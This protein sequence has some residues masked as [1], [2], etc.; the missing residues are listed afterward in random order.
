MKNEKSMTLNLSPP[1]EAEKEEERSDG[2]QWQTA[3]KQYFNGKKRKKGSLKRK[4]G[5]LKRSRTMT[6]NV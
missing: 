4:K 1:T 3:F 2:K 5:G 6:S